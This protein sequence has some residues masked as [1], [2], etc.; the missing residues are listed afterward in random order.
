MRAKLDQD[1][2]RAMDWRVRLL[3]RCVAGARDEN[4]AAAV[5]FAVSLI[6]LAP[7]M[8][9]IFDIYLA[10]TQRNNLQDALDAAA[11]F[12]ARST[13]TTSGAVDAV[14]DA[15]LTA[16]LV[17]PTGATLVA[18][19]FTL[20]GDK[21]VG[22][23]EVTP[24]ALAPGVWN[25]TN[26]KAN[27]EVVR[28]LDRLE[29]AL[30]LDNT[31]SMQGTKLAT[32]KDAAAALVDKLVEA[33]ARS[34]Q[35][36]P[37]KIALV[38]FSTTVRVQGTT[39]LTSYNPTNRTGPGIPTWIDP[40]ASAH[41]S[42]STNNDIFE[43]SSGSTTKTDRFTMMKNIGQSWGG[44]VE[45]RRQPYDI[46]EDAASSA[47]P[48]SMFIPYFWPDEPDSNHYNNYMNDGGASGL[49]ARQKQRRTAKYAGGSMARSGAFSLDGSGYGAYSLGPNAG[50][51]LQPVIPLTTSSAS[52]KTG[53]TNMTAVGETNIPLGLV[54][55]WHAVAPSGPLTGGS[56]YGTAHVRKIIILM[57]DG[58]NTMNNPSRSGESNGSFY[59]GLGYIWQNMLG[60]TSSDGN[61]RANAIDTRLALLCTA[62]KAKD[63]VVYTVRVE[64]NSGSS[65]LLQNCASTPDKF[66]DVQDV[67][68]LQAA[69]DAIAGS[70]DNL[71]LAK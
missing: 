46:R 68:D 31:G 43:V 17:L 55:G 64:V 9:G 69:F 4:G 2:T 50:C 14:G 12:A 59:G 71:R 28:S 29:I 62:V 52:I 63:I 34:V 36:D 1:K 25:H 33:S 23:A 44:C 65:S 30:V 6:L 26:V 35:T 16:N 3:R 37:L 15:A 13:G 56:P 58:N 19:N 54:W 66:Y 24:P 42:G 57:T 5:F 53:I 38:P 60:T 27:A 21:V 11:L 67:D 22:Y 32:L 48:A 45:Q 8:L 41:W 39:A 47:T 49:T 18:S 70:I 7:L 20:V 10:S 40:L 51:T 61:V